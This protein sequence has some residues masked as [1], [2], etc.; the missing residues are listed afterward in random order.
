VSLDALRVDAWPSAVKT[1][2]ANF[3][4][5]S[6]L[7]DIPLVIVGDPE[8]A[9]TDCTREAPSGLV[10]EALPPNQ[11]PYAV[12][13]SQ[14]CDVDE[15]GDP[16]NPFVQFAPVVNRFALL[17]PG[18]DMAIKN[19]GWADLVYLTEQPEPNGFWVADL[20]YIGSI[21]KGLLVGQSPREGFTTE[22]DRLIF[23]DRLARRFGRAAFS[24]PVQDCVITSLNKWIAKN[25]S[26]HSLKGRSTFTGVEEVCLRVEGDRLAPASVQVVVFQQ[27][28]LEAADKAAWEEWRNNTKGDLK[29]HPE[30][31]Q[32]PVT[33]L[34]PIQFSTLAMPASEYRTLTPV[35]L[36]A[37]QRGP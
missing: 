33:F 37:L 9:T 13:T 7:K 21:E 26:K 10:R 22:A 32:N 4:Q 29:A 16:A 35:P 15:A 19:G 23:A 12:I 25:W 34:K 28:P 2:T 5:G 20:R 36:S 8:N 14:T 18:D 24:G 30:N 3:R 1:A 11:P 6:L 27:T 17:N 31:T